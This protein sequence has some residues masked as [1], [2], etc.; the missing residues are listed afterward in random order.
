LAEKK[1]THIFFLCPI[2]KKTHG[3]SI[4]SEY[5]AKAEGGI[6]SIPFE[7]GEPRHLVIVEVDTFGM[8]RNVRV[9]KKPSEAK[10]IELKL[11]LVD[12]V[13]KLGSKLLSILTFWVLAG[14][15]VA[16]KNDRKEQIKLAGA[17]INYVSG[18]VPPNSEEK[19][20][21]DIRNPKV[22]LVTLDPLI[23]IYEYIENGKIKFAN[24]WIDRELKR[25]NEGISTLEKLC[26]VGKKYKKKELLELMGEKFRYDEIIMLIEVLRYRDCDVDSVFDV[27]E[28]KVKR[29]LEDII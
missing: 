27:K 22:P 6:T 19:I 8:V 2:C 16:L 10:K 24:F 29:L 18:L 25:L 5:L 13:K 20:D 15:K 9:P 7:H 3:F 26:R 4:S 11:D 21:V 23:R 12:I 1:E 14:K 28:I 17:F